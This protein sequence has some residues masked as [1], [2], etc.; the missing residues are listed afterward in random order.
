MN[1][2]FSDTFPSDV[3]LCFVPVST[4]DQDFSGV[5]ESL[6]VTCGELRE[7]LSKKSTKEISSV[8]GSKL[9]L[10]LKL[11]A[12][13]SL[14]AL[15]HKFRKNARN[16]KDYPSKSWVLN[17]LHIHSSETCEKLTQ[18]C[19]H[20]LITSTQNIGKS[21]TTTDFEHS[22]CDKNASLTI[23]SEYSDQLKSKAEEF[24]NLAMAHL[25]AMN[26]GNAPSNKKDV[27]YMAAYCE[28]L[29]RKEGIEIEIFQKDRLEIEGFR[30]L[31]AVNRGSEYPAKFILLKYNLTAIDRPL[32]ALVG[33][34]VLFDTGGINLKPSDNLFLM[35]S[36]MCGAAAV[37]SVLEAVARSKLNIRLVVAIPLTDNAIDAKSTKPGDVI[38]SY[39][40]KTI[41]VIDTDAEGRLCLADAISYVCRNYSPDYLI[42][43]ATL[44]GSAAR[45]LGQ[46]YAALFSNSDELSGIL[47]HLGNLTGEKVWRMPLDEAYREDLH[48]D[49][50]DLANYSNKPT[51]GAISAA[52]FLQEFVENTRH[53]AHIDI[54]GTAYTSSEFGKQRNATGYGVVLLYH[55]IKKISENEKN[56]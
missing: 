20:G 16:Y 26:L 11:D 42:D 34:G 33:K 24:K 9:Y 50:A 8:V 4:T 6:G 22:L 46:H 29:A 7:F 27:N 40:G 53:W 48:S 55:F 54:A 19:I 2:H 12:S 25:H 51:A 13:E 47:S 10:F 52:L 21:K 49:V 5:L 15:I 45:A 39:N 3:T 56:S 17:L 32:V 38:G 23:I 44:T 28:V 31:L 30:A 37:L 43:I 35:K 41:E 14:V 36:D 1:V 18:A